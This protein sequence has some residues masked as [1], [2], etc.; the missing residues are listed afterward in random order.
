ML[1]PCRRRLVTL[2]QA[3]RHGYGW[4]LR[5][6]EQKRTASDVEGSAKTPET[7]RYHNLLVTRCWSTATLL[8]LIFIGECRWDSGKETLIIVDCIILEPALF[9]VNCSAVYEPTAWSWHHFLRV[10]VLSQPT[11]IV[12]TLGGTRAPLRNVITFDSCSVIQHQ[13]TFVLEWIPAVCLRIHGHHAFTAGYYRLNVKW[14]LERVE[15]S[16]HRELD[17]QM[18]CT[19]QSELIEALT[20]GTIGFSILYRVLCEALH[21][22]SVFSKD[23]TQART[24]LKACTQ[25]VALEVP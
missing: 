21:I 13:Q 2:Q 6:T 19:F 17:G 9:A 7:W 25:T 24:T 15:R 10:M 1:Q 16:Q 8:L 22:W 4:F 3:A 12:S 18:S 5:P 14:G 23:K 11:E 20:S